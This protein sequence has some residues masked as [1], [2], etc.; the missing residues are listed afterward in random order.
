MRV[1]VEQ[2]SGMAF[3]VE[4]GL[5]VLEWLIS[6]SNSCKEFIKVAGLIGGESKSSRHKGIG[7]REDKSKSLTIRIYPSIQFI[8]VAVHSFF[9]RG[10]LK[11]NGAGSEKAMKKPL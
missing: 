4:N 6:K 5:I 11:K 8:K 1:V 7:L 9:T 3:D 2:F 10:F